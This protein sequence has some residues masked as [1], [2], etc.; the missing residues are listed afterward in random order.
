M[1]RAAAAL[2][3]ICVMALA[4]PVSGAPA[5]KVKKDPATERQI[6][7]LRDQVAE[8]SVE[9]TDLLGRLDEAEDR[10]R[11]LDADV[12][13]VDGEL[14]GEQEKVDAAHR[15][16]DDATAE[17][18][19]AQL[20]LVRARSQLAGARETLHR[21]VVAA[22]VHHPTAQVANL[23]FR[24]HSLRQYSA[25]K[26]YLQTL[27]HSQHAAV[28]AYREMRARAEVSEQDVEVHLGQTRDRFEEAAARTRE[29]EA[30]REKADA[31]RGTA[32][33]EEQTQR[34]LVDEVQARK[35]EFE[36]RLA[37]LQ[38]QSSGVTA[39]LRARPSTG[40]GAPP[41]PGT[42]AAPIPNTTITSSFGPRI[43]PIYGNV[44]M[45]AGIDLRGAMG[46]PILAA[47]DGVVVAADLRGGYGNATVIDH[48]N[49]LATLYG[50]Q[51]AMFVTA[52]QQVAR[53]AVIGLVGST[54]FSTGPHLHFEVR[55]HGVPVDPL[56]YL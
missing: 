42:L 23:M 40:P 27:A 16:V 26:A 10:R 50:H 15:L 36:E 46:T 18:V 49:G 56:G 17:L 41:A 48:G 52:G 37:D 54:G 53:G 3:V 34:A 45:H 38:V 20:E 6:H 29:L 43:H 24:A 21:R 47:G 2:A 11:T 9:E 1:P 31:V 55:V 4:A 35:A 30:V 44:R 39:L 32:L 14:A 51:S 22:Y 33:A 25:S 8:A 28:A 5:R 12:A 13:T 7:T 19:R